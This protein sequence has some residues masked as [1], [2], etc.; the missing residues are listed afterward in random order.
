MRP[1]LEKIITSLDINQ[2]IKILKNP[3]ELPKKPK[4][5]HKKIKLAVQAAKKGGSISP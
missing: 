2:I 3:I 4:P 5:T 1:E